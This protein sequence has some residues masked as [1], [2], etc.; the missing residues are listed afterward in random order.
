MKLLVAFIFML[1]PFTTFA[2]DEPEAVY[3]KFHRAVMSGNIEEMI[4][5]GPTSRRAELLSMSEASRD[6]ALK[7]AQYMMPRAFTL[8]RKTVQPNGRSTLIVSGPWTSEGLK[9]E[10]V[11]GVIRMITEDG[12]WK[13]D[14]SSWT[15]Q[16]PDNLATPQPAAPPAA[17]AKAP[18]SAAVPVKGAAAAAGAPVVG[19][20]NSTTPGRTLGAAKPDCVYKPV[21]TA[22]DMENCK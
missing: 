18:S 3:A 14:E 8:Q 2:A 7:M 5:Y 16:R 9:L 10:T 1:L 19:S 11:Y 13:V 12:E 4:K 17:A 20:M 6:A 22:R 15:N 21:M